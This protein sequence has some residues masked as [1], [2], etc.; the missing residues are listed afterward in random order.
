MS[1]PLAGIKIVDLTSVVMGPYATQILGDMGAE[2]IKVES[3]DGDILRQMGEGRSPAMGPIHMT[4]NRNKKSLMLDLRNPAAKAG[5]L[6]V[7]QKADMLIHALRPAAIE[8]LGLGYEA[9]RLINPD[10]VYCGAYGYGK[11]GPYADDPAYDDMIQAMSGICDLNIGLA[12]EP[13]YTPTILGDKVAGLTIAYGVLGALVHKLRT[14]QGQFVEVPML[15]SLVSFTLQ[16]HLWDRVF[17][18]E[19]GVVGYP[20]VLSRLRR[21]YRTTDGYLCVMPYTDKN[22]QQFFEATGRADL[23]ANPRYATANGRSS[24]YEILYEE[25]SAIIAQRSCAEW[26]ALLKPL[27]IPVAPVN[28]L[29][30]LFDDPH[31]K[32]VGMFAQMQHPTEGTVTQ[33][34]PP[35]GFE[36]SPNE[37]RRLAPRLGEHSR[38]L[39]AEAGLTQAEIDELVAAGATL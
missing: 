18:A 35:V 27:S 13:R 36:A 19:H 20:R 10:I 15:E 37:I 11:E 14:G 30:D 2:V 6:R 26:L 22:W 28:R 25:L 34:R 38:E 39:L 8:R 7:V 33:V 21:P 24:S 9:V 23:A 1:G 17:D 16:E 12:G 5:L 29:T 31:L 3:P 4:I 32:A